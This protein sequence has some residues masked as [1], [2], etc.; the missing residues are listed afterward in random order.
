MITK[1]QLGKYPI[2]QSVLEY[3][4]VH[5]ILFHNTYNFIINSFDENYLAFCEE[6]LSA[7]KNRYP[8]ETDFI[9]SIKAFIKYSNEYLILQTKLNRAGNYLY[10]SFNEVNTNVYQNDRTMNQYYLDGLLLSQFLWPNHYKMALKSTLSNT[11][12]FPPS[13]AL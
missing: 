13:P 11:S 6:I 4:K 3:I 8:T 1:N 5:Y 2:V 10:S 12:S 7:L 9:N